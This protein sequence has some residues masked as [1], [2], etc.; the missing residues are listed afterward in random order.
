MS[1][2]TREELE[3]GLDEIRA[4]PKDVGVVQLI[5]CRPAVGGREVREEGL[6]DLVHGLVGDNWAVRG[7]SRT[8]DGSAHPDMQL[9]IMG[10]RAIALIARAKARWPLAGDQLFIDMDLS[11][12]NMPPGTWLAMGSA[13][14]EIT[15]IPHTGC[16]KFHR[17]FGLEATKFVNSALGKALHLRGLNAKVVQSGSVR[18]GDTIRK[19]PRE[20]FGL[21]GIA[22][23][24]Q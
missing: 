12:D 20:A 23:T 8:A 15:A 9:N 11:E 14:V 18:I 2:V 19:A 17:R 22:V 4:A 16:E 5:V 3:A 1:D 13:I 21:T 24:V 10:S 7:S 6:L